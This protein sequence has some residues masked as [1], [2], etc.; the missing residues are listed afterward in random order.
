MKFVESH[1]RGNFAHRDAAGA[2]AACVERAAQGADGEIE[3]LRARV[4]E[5]TAVVGRLIDEIRAL[6]AD[7]LERILDYNFTVTE[8]TK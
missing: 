1:W 8:D 5:L 2:V 6:R 3:R 7:Q 4:D